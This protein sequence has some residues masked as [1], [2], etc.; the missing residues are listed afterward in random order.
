M[1]L[2]E[3]FVEE[4]ETKAEGKEA[5]QAESQEYQ[6]Q[7]QRKPFNAM[8]EWIKNEID[9]MKLRNLPC[10]SCDDGEEES[11]AGETIG[12]TPTKACEGHWIG[13]TGIVCSILA[14]S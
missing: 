12:D 2:E 11:R 13:D 7:F 9:D 10:Q 5:V 1:G 14:G 3:M 6:A 8:T 4:E